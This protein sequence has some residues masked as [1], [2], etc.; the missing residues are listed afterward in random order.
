MEGGLWRRDE[1]AS[2]AGLGLSNIYS[3]YINVENFNHIVALFN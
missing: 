2:W 1:V 3:L